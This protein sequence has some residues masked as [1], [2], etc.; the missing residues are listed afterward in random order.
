MFTQLDPHIP[1]H[2]LGKGAGQAIGVIDYGAEHHLIWVTAI[3]ETGEI[4]CAPNPRV[5]MQSNWTLGRATSAAVRN[6][7]ERQ[8]VTDEPCE[9]CAGL[10]RL[11]PE[12]A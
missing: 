12:Q 2:V 7:R 1:L 5:R 8:D 3:G 4:W 11:D 10:M 9:E 6:E